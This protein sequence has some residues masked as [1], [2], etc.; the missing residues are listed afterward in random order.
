MTNKK[1]LIIGISLLLFTSIIHSQDSID[2]SRQSAITR[3][4]E[5]ASPAV[6]SINVVQLKEYSTQS[7]YNDPFFR[8][9]L[10]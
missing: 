6:A 7:Y 9:L 5:K 3:A 2:D 8:Y 10:P 1:K 4:I